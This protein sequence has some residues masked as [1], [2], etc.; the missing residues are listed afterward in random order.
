M[1]RLSLFISSIALVCS[2]SA[3]AQPPRLD[4][5]TDREVLARLPRALPPLAGVRGL[6]RDDITI[7]KEKWGVGV[8]NCSVHYKETIRIWGLEVGPFDRVHVVKI[9]PAS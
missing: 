2:Q 5:P 9:V 8:W 4:V 6:F 1:L 7:V 3:M